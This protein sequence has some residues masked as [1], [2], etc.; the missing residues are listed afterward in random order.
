[1]KLTIR[2][3]MTKGV[4]TVPHD[5][6]LEYAEH[7]IREW[8]VRHLPVVKNG[9]A[10]GML[11]QKD[12]LLLRTLPGYDPKKATCGEAVGESLYAVPPNMPLAQVARTMI[13]RRI[14]S[15]LVVE[16]GKPVGIF[17]LVD[18]LAALEKLAAR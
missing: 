1:M 7:A 9:K 14:G 10:I 2:E 13:D 18:A 15:A 12:L 16:A 3:V 11:S 8:E 4:K 5:A 6:T 17:T